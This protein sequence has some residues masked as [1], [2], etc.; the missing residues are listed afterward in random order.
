MITSI[1]RFH[2]ER[3]SPAP[4]S[5]P[6]SERTQPIAKPRAD[7]GTGI[8]DEVG[9]PA[10]KGNAPQTRAQINSKPYAPKPDDKPPLKAYRNTGTQNIK[11][12]TNLTGHVKGNANG[13]INFG[14]L[15]ASSA[16]H[17]CSNTPPSTQPDPNMQQK[18]AAF[19]MLVETLNAID[20]GKN[21]TAT[22]Q[23][24]G[25]RP[26]GSGKITKGDD[27]NN[28][29]TQNITGLSNL[30]GSTEGDANGAINFGELR[31]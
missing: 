31:C 21:D 29:G 5:A 14:N 22:S 3:P 27:F 1:F 4:T 13:A 24:S 19:G 7:N 9:S 10:S 17:S 8:V 28:T 20:D 16:A 15:S 18:M 6:S 26:S 25:S 12:L 23:P 2:R 30:T 11:G